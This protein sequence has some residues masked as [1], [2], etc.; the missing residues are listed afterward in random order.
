MINK[1]LFAKRIANIDNKNE[2]LQNFVDNA[3]HELKTPLA[4]INSSLW[5]MKEKKQFDGN[6]IDKSIR[7]IENTNLLIETLRDL[8]NITNSSKKEHLDI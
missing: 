5:I 1:L 6:L 8:S 4:V 7:E 3:G 2:D